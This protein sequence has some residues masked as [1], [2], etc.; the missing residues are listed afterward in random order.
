MNRIYGPAPRPFRL[1]L[2]L[3]EVG[4]DFEQ[5]L[6]LRAG[7]TNAYYGLASCLEGLGDL[8]G[9]RGAMRAYLHLESET[10][11]TLAYRRRAAAAL[12]EWDYAR[13]DDQIPTESEGEGT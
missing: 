3:E 4:V 12:W 7:Q 6:A 2:V 10:T 9:A 5:A 11:D 1:S 8:A 13:R